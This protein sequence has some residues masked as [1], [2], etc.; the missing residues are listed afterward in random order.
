M[1]GFII[2]AFEVLRRLRIGAAALVAALGAIL[3]AAG[4][5]SYQRNQVWTSAIA[6][7]ED[8]V[9]KSPAKRRPRFQLAFAYYEA[10]RCADAVR[11]FG[12]T[13]EIAPPDYDHLVDW[14]LSYDCLGHHGEALAKLRQAAALQPGAHAQSLIGMI[15]A[16]QSHWGQALEALALAEKLNPGFAMTYVY[17]GNIY[18]QTGRPAI[19]LPEFE[20]AL[21][22]EPQNPL[23]LSGLATAQ[24]ALRRRP[25]A[26]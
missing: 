2:A 15:Y 20:R 4:V 14:A 24:A 26:R 10:N 13:A 1:I 19:A 16:K 7:W 6:L 11:E 21:A 5:A 18:L 22:V 9:K 17:R 3:A 12:R 25:V 8:T 23:A